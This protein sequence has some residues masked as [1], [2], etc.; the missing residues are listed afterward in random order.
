MLNSML[1]LGTA[2]AYAHA[3]RQLLTVANGGGNESSPLLYGALYEVK[4]ESYSSF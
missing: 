2:L 4:F 3:Q 1:V